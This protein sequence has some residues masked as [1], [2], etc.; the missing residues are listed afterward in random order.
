MCISC[1]VGSND[2]STCC[3]STFIG[4]TVH[5]VSDVNMMISVEQC[6]IRQ[7]RF[8]DRDIHY[9]YPQ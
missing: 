3:K 9:V 2:Y 5:G 1:Q 7:W 4:D 6:I 8:T